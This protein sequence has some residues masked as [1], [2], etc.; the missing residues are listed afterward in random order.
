MLPGVSAT[1]RRALSISAALIWGLFPAFLFYLLFLQ[2]PV[3]SRSR[4][5]VAALLVA[6]FAVLAHLAMPRWMSFSRRVFLLLFLSSGALALFAK[7][8]ITFYPGEMYL[9][10]GQHI[11][12]LT[13]QADDGQLVEV[14]GLQTGLEDV[15]YASFHDV[16]GWKQRGN[17]LVPISFP[18]PPLTWTGWTGDQARL[19]L[20]GSSDV[21]VTMDWDGQ[22]QTVALGH[23]G[24]DRQIMAH[25]FPMPLWGAL[26]MASCSRQL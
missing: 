3:L 13:V 18:P 21:T 20:W 19:Y 9:F 15:S 12:H 8:A 10:F 23:A 25:V 14:R 2:L 17:T 11:L 26:F 1:K 24:V 6:F 4:L 22:S 7:E 5:G 16:I